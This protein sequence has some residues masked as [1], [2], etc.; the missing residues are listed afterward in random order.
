MAQIDPTTL[1]ITLILQLV[2]SFKT[3]VFQVN[4]KVFQVNLREPVKNYLADFFR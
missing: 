2:L 1:P 4:L 3:Q